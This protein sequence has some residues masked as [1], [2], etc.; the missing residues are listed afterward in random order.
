MTIES[1]ARGLLL[2]PFFAVGCAS[3]PTTSEAAPPSES[4][5]TESL[6]APRAEEGCGVFADSRYGNDDNEGLKDTPVQTLAR[7]IALA[8]TGRRRVFACTEHYNDATVNL[9]TG[10][11]LW[12]GFDCQR[13]WRYYGDEYRA[14]IQVV[15][16]E[17][18]VAVNVVPVE[19]EGDGLDDGIS[20]IADMDLYAHDGQSL[21]RPS[22][23]VVVQPGAVA[24]VLRGHIKA[25]RGAR[26]WN[27]ENASSQRPTD[28][29]FGKVGVEA[30][31]A[32]TAAGGAA[33]TTV[34]DDGRTSIGGKGGDGHATSGEDGSDGAPMS[35][36]STL[37]RGHG[38]A[39]ESS[40]GQQCIEGEHGQDGEP[41]MRGAGGRGVGRISDAGEWV[42]VS[43]GD[44]GKGAP[45]HG[46]GGGGGA[47]GGALACGAGFQG[48]ASGGSGGAGGCGGV[49]AKGGGYGGASIAVLV[50][51][52]GKITLH[53]T[54]IQTGGLGRGG[55]G[56]RSQPGG[57]GGYGGP[58]GRGN[59]N[60]ARAGCRGG[61]G[62][63]GGYGGYGG[64][65][66]GG[67][68]I[69]IAY[70][71][72]EQLTLDGV[73]FKLGKGGTRGRSLTLDGSGW[74]EDGIVSEKVRFP[75]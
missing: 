37:M 69:G 48:G 59:N 58:E 73:T 8:R 24:E 21:G 51:H 67:P 60:R 61:D 72:E 56:G 42:G 38:G 57:F 50:L 11:D 45:G 30:C 26:G 9:P 40:D 62:G 31:T 65:G 32:A 46:G 1:A 34:C 44:G 36:P 70:F 10:I 12:G 41:G 20:T 35:Q 28:G 22:I 16:D 63:Y 6:A 66:A 52:G 29:A 53:G 49:G 5:C 2:V 19:G 17:S 75:R 23:A 15:G 47:R 4:F 74:G 43:G 18:M 3:A 25:G 54:L 33:V 14:S 27:A 13:E 39:G 64:G 55:D 71:D 68:S 7:A